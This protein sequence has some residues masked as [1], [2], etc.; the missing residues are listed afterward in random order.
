V[1][2]YAKITLLANREMARRLAWGEPATLGIYAE[3]DAAHARREDRK[4]FCDDATFSGVRRPSLDEV[5]RKSRRMTANVSKSQSFADVSIA[6][7]ETSAYNGAAEKY[8]FGFFAAHSLR[9][10]ASAV[11]LQGAGDL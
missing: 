7:D 3:K 11:I 4:I 8:G 1:T 5:S 2:T 10:A 6:S 9:A